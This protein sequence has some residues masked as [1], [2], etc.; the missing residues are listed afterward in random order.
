MVILACSPY[1]DILSKL[2]HL[3][4]EERGS[5]VVL[6]GKQQVNT[7]SRVLWE[8]EY[9]TWCVLEGFGPAV[10]RKK[11]NCWPW[12]KQGDSEQPDCRRG[13]VM[14]CGAARSSAESSR[15]PSLGVTILVEVVSW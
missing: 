10:N 6:G 7:G 1:C 4:K 3:P 12:R 8:M 9:G 15:V 14:D 13:S 5:S 11:H 2:R